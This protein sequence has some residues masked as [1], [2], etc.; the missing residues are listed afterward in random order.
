MPEH[1]QEGDIPEHSGQAGEGREQSKERFQEKLK[2]TKAQI[3]KI[4]QEEK[5]KK[6]FNTSLSGIIVH[7]LKK[8]DNDEIIVLISDLVESNVPSDF[9]LSIISIYIKEAEIYITNQ[10]ELVLTTGHSQ[11]LVLSNIKN[12][13]FS[14]EVNAK[15]TNWGNLVVKIALQDAQKVLETVIQVETWSTHPSLIK[16]SVMVLEKFLKNKKEKVEHKELLQF[17]QSFLE[18]IFEQI[19]KKLN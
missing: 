4:H 16:L 9:I 19:Q 2:K 5:K 15:I 3:K 11:K 18:N 14:P 8:G 12:N 17:A 10:G 7:L 6:I 13:K 1:Y